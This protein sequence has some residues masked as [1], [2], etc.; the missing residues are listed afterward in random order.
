M[1]AEIPRTIEDKITWLWDK[2]Y[3]DAIGCGRSEETAEAYA[4]KETAELRARLR[5][6]Q[7]MHAENCFPE[8]TV[9]EGFDLPEGWKDDSWHNDAMPKFVSPCGFYFLWVDY[10]NPDHREWGRNFKRYLIVK[11]QEAFNVGVSDEEQVLLSDSFDDVRQ[12]INQ[13]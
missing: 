2:K 13:I 8:W 6:S 4:N 9:P 11:V 12:F 5:A 7:T 10:E 1:H 3:Q